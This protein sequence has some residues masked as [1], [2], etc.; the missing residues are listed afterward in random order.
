MDYEKSQ[1][2]IIFILLRIAPTIILFI[3]FI[4]PREV[5]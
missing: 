3:L 2:K 4:D 5:N 1:Q